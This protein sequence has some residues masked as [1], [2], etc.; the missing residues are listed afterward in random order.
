MEVMVQAV[1]A[2][3]LYMGTV[4]E[5]VRSGMMGPLMDIEMKLVPS[6]FAI[7][8]GIQWCQ[9]SP[10]SKGLQAVLF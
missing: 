1:L 4:Q 5:I 3:R 7:Y 6:Y 2:H 10:T 9:E 8:Q